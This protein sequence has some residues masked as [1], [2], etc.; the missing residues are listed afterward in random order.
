[1]SELGKERISTP[2]F[3]PLLFVSI[4][5]I[6]V[7]LL[8]GGNLWQRRRQQAFLLFF[9]VVECKAGRGD[10][11]RGDEDDEI[12]FDVLINIRTEEATNQRNLRLGVCPWVTQFPDDFDD[13]A[14]A[15]FGPVEL[16]RRR[17]TQTRLSAS[18]GRLRFPCHPMQSQSRLELSAIKPE[19]SRQNCAI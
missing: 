5:V 12:S 7:S 6:R 11:S 2:W 16:D 14:L 4:S 17:V 3:S 8:I 15:A 18:P 9:L 19:I 10:H 13:G 1:M